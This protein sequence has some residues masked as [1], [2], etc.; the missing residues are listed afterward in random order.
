MRLIQEQMQA[1]REEARKAFDEGAGL[2]QLG[3]RPDD[4][5]R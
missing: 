3:S 4:D 2:R 5:R 1:I